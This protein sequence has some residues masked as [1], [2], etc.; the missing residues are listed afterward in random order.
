MEI[1]SEQQT[2]IYNDKTTR[3]CFVPYGDD[4]ATTFLE[5]TMVKIDVY[6]KNPARDSYV[7]VNECAYRVLQNIT[8]DNLPYTL[9]DGTKV[10]VPGYIIDGL[11]CPDFMETRSSRN[12]YIQNDNDDDADTVQYQ[13]SDFR[14]VMKPLHIVPVQYLLRVNRDSRERMYHYNDLF[15]SSYVTVE[16]N[17]RQLLFDSYF[18]DSYSATIST[19]EPLTAKQM[20]RNMSDTIVPSDY[21]LYV[22]KDFPV[23]IEKHRNVII[24]PSIDMPQIRKD[25]QTLWRWKSYG[26]EDFSNWREYVPNKERILLFESKNKVLTVSPDMLGPQFIELYCMDVYGNIIVNRDGG[27]IFVDSPDEFSSPA[28]VRQ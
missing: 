6:Y 8:V 3:T 12:I 19:F 2:A 11:F 7:F 28:T 26:I 13:L 25:Y 5:D 15:Y 18:D 9:D 14:F 21:M 17:P 23:T 22:Y 20:W 10:N 16:Y 24:R 27:N 1:T 4:Y